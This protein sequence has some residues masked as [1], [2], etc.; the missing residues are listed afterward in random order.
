MPKPRGSLIGSFFASKIML[1]TPLPKWYLVSK[2]H[3]VL[4]YTPKRDFEPFGNAVSDA[5]RAR[6]R[7]P[8]QVII[9]DT[10][11]L[12]GN[13][14]YRKT[15]TNQERHRNVEYSSEIKA[16][17][18]VNEPYFCGLVS[19]DADTYEVKSCKKTISLRQL[20]VSFIKTLRGA[21]WNSTTTAS[22]SISIAVIFN[23]EMDPDT[24]SAYMALSG[25]S[26][27]SLVKPEL[28]EAF[29]ANHLRAHW[30]LQTDT[31]EH[32]AYDKRTPG[33]FKE[34]WQG[35]GIIGLCSKTYYFF[36]AKDKFRCKGVSKGLYTIDK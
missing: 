26:L 6:D 33:L 17:Q 28:R 36:G 24:D 10:T 9:A 35:N 7:D 20:A 3:Q 25:E 22:T 21:Y 12:V 2:I 16:S 34:E 27:E 32:R 23:S 30:F 18:L 19:I 5:R 1:L 31:V 29:E 8:D 11:K 15:I 13:S 4:E 14:S